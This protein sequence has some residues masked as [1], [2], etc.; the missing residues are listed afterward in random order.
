MVGV[1]RLCAGVLCGLI[2]VLGAPSVVASA[3][4]LVVDLGSTGGFGVASALFDTPFA[5][6][7][8]TI[9]PTTS[10]H[11]GVVVDDAAAGRMKASA[12]PFNIVPPFILTYG[13]TTDIVTVTASCFDPAG[14]HLE[15][16]DVQLTVNVVAPPPTIIDLGSVVVGS[17]IP[18]HLPLTATSINC[19]FSGG[20][21]ANGNQVSLGPFAVFTAVAPGTSRI[22]LTTQCAHGIKPPDTVIVLANVVDAAVQV[23]EFPVSVLASLSPLVV[24]AMYTTRRRKRR[25]N[26]RV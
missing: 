14:T 26:V 16:L 13:V 10:V 19:P 6:P 5:S 23:P 12:F 21:D 9:L 1:K 15:T 2:G 20:F 8:C 7:R 22:T 3:A 17:T 4:P 18:L 24:G 11:F 25:R